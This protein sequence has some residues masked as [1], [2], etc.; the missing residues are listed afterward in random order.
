MS[1]N[2]QVKFEVVRVRGCGGAIIEMLLTPRKDKPE[3][4]MSNPEIARVCV[5]QKLGNGRT[6]PACVAWY[7][8]NLKKPG[9]RAK[10]GVDEAKYGK[11]KDLKVE[12]VSAEKVESKKS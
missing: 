10:Q 7:V 11:Y 8:S 1:Q 6:T 3:C 2:T 9:F 12:K 5:E 4:R